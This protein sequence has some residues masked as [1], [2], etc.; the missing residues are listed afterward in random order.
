MPRDQTRA[1][2]EGVPKIDVRRAVRELGREMFAGHTV[3]LETSNGRQPVG[4]VRELRKPFGGTRVFF[5]CGWCECR[6][7]ILY[8]RRGAWACRR[9]HG[10]AH[11]VEAL[12]LSQRRVRRL[13]KLRERIGQAPGGGVLGPLPPKP[14]RMR[15]R[16]YERMAAELDKLQRRHLS[17][18]FPA[19]LLR[20]FSR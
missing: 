20:R 15:W 19:S 4:L 16:T 17:A 14:K 18:P 8:L 1:F 7:C 12:S 11:W 5:R 13:V 3:A 9:C 2:V 6:V 10:L